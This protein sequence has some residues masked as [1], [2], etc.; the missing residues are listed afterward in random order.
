MSEASRLL[1]PDTKAPRG[2]ELADVSTISRRKLFFV[3][4]F[5]GGKALGE[6]ERRR[7]RMH[8]CWYRSSR[9]PHCCWAASE[10]CAIAFPASFLHFLF[11][12]QK[13][14]R[15]NNNKTQSFPHLTSLYSPTLSVS[16]EMRPPFKTGSHSSSSSLRHVD[17]AQQRERGIDYGRDLPVKIN[18]NNNTRRQEEEKNG[19]KCMQTRR[20][21]KKRWLFD[22]VTARPQTR[23][24]IT[25][26]RIDS[27]PSPPLSS[28][29]CTCLTTSVVAHRVFVDA[30]TLALYIEEFIVRPRI[31]QWDKIPLPFHPP[32]QVQPTM[33]FFPRYFFFFLILRLTSLLRVR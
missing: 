13:R 16:V 1:T 6:Q 22:I 23:W 25:S 9:R 29:S 21:A 26:F 8:S 19:G 31:P 24:E 2:K 7:P 27:A 12:A 5:Y 18:N 3:F 20:I 14:R 15:N 11:T 30:S 17:D 28:F 10:M 33:M 32:S 4:F